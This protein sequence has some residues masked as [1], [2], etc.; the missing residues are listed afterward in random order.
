MKNRSFLNDNWDIITVLVVYSILAFFSLKYFQYRI[1]GDEISYINIAKAYSAG[2][3]G[4]AINGYWSPLYSWLMSP[5]LFF[6]SQPFYA[7]YVSKIVSI[8]IGFFTIIS[9]RRL[10]RTFEIDKIVE[11]SFLIVLIPFI[12]YFS[13]M[14]NTPDLL[15]V[16]FI[17]YYLS[18]I[19]ETKYSNNLINGVLCGFIGTL[20]YLTKSFAFPFFLFHFILF[21]LI[22][23]F[24]ELNVDRRK[25]LKNLFLGLA[26]FFV[27][28]GL[29]VGTISEKYG[30]LT[31]STAGEYNQAL[32]GSEYGVNTMEYG[33][34]PIYYLGLIK[35]PNN[36][37][38][39]IWDDLSYQKMDHWSPLDSLK[40][41]EYELKLIWSNIGYTFKL[42]ESFIFISFIILISMVLF[43]LIPKVDKVSKNAVKCLLLT[44]LI[45]IGG[46]CIIIPEWRY[47]WLIFILLIF[48]GFFIIDRLYKSKVINYTIR[49]IL[50]V[51]MICLFVMQPI[52]EVVLFANPP[53]D[54][55]YN[56][57][58]ILKIDYGVQGNIAS[59]S[60]WMDT[61]TISYYL[62]S[63][64]Y[65][66]TRKTNSTNDLQQQL[67][68]NKIDYY[69]VWNS[70]INLN[71][72]DY[73]EITHGE[74]PLL[75]I[76]KRN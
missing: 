74:I 47:L 33:L 41:F 60:E 22:Y 37:A 10:S 68:D 17:V 20:A 13:L 35:P 31:I 15:L 44:M 52:S 72:S 26:V 63:K 70:T 53:E 48:S 21:N 25:V 55:D 46:Y 4:A 67:E 50:L 1:A 9:V 61:L 58:N 5:F 23:Y 69:L 6:G 64:Y 54:N 18:I 56:L 73:H 36:Y 24:K 71:L 59:N 32:V 76:Y 51:I 49:N 43:I 7:V 66:M 28:S 3:W 39:S 29:W 11:R 62:N 45:Y 27:L 12:L 75:Q 8:I 2:N 38:T 14:Y 34:P 65:G 16:C 42:L 19:F 40:N 30:K 57:S